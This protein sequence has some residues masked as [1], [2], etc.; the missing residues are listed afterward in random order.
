MKAPMIDENTSDGFHTFKELYEHR[1][2]LFI[3]LCRHLVNEPG[4]SVWRS[5]LN[6]DGA[7]WPGW[8]VA[9]IGEGRGGITYHLP[10]RLWERMDFAKTIDRGIWDGHTSNDVLERLRSL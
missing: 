1:F 4:R 3:A 9:G 10:D 6:S 8:F 2:G 7:S 5:R